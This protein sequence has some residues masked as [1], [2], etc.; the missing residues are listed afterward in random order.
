[1]S[2]RIPS[3]RVVFVLNTVGIALRVQARF[4]ASLPASLSE[5]AHTHICHSNSFF[6]AVLRLQ[7]VGIIV[8]GRKEGGKPCVD[9]GDVIISTV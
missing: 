1:M 2:R 4:S 7:V 6:V 8:A 3:G 5:S 9:G